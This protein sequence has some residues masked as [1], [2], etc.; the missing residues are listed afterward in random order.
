MHT[1]LSQ[2]SLIFREVDSLRI[3]FS[4]EV[5]VFIFLRKP[6]TVYFTRVFCVIPTGIRPSPSNMP[7]RV[8]S[9]RL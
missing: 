5:N 2:I 7:L 9:Q 1:I 4:L 3:L 6:F 8:I